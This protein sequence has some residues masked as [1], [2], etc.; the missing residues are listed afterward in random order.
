VNRAGKAPAGA[1]LLNRLRTLGRRQLFWP[2]VTMTLLI[3]FNLVSNPHFF[4]VTIR[5]GHLYG[6]R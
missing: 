2:I 3:L 6:K 1:S 5:D 4:A